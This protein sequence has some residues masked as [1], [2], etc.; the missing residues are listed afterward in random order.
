VWVIGSSFANPDSKF[1][2]YKLSNVQAVV[3]VPE[4]ATWMM[5]IAG[6]GIVG[7]ASRRKAAGR[8]SVV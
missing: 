3:A 8:L 1:D 7:A 4:S 6:F 2:A 5:M